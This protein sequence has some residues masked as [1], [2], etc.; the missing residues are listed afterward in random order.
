VVSESKEYL[1]EPGSNRAFLIRLNSS[2]LAVSFSLS[3][4][5][6]ILTYC[7]DFIESSYTF[8]IKEESTGDDA[9][10]LKGCNKSSPKK[11]VMA[12]NLIRIGKPVCLDYK[13]RTGVINMQ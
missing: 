5:A 9:S 7:K 13:R 2:A 10:L 8:S 11:R 6:L 4:R 1:N 3:V 12:A